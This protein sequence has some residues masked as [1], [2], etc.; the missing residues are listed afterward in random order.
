MSATKL[1]FMFPSELIPPEPSLYKLSTIPPP[2]DWVI[3]V[4]EHGNDL[5]CYGDDYWDYSAFGYRGF[6]FSI[7]KLSKANLKFVKQAMLLVLYHPNL[8]PG[9]LKSC[10]V[11][12]NCLTKIAK[13][14]DYQGIL[15]TDLPKFPRVQPLVAKSLQ[16]SQY[17]EYIS[18]LH[19]LRIF[20]DVVRFEIADK[21]TLA[22]LAS[23]QLDRE[24]VQ[25]PYIPPRIWSYQVNRLNEVL[26]DFL[27]HQKSIKM[28][29]TW[30][31]DARNHNQGVQI[32][33]I[34]NSPFSEPHLHQDKRIVYKKGFD[35]F[36]NRYGLRNL[37]EKWLEPKKSR[38]NL[39][40][41]YLNFVRDAALIYIANFS[42]QRIS[43][44]LSLRTD[45]FDIE[46]DERL[47]DVAL[48]SGKTT[49]T[50]PDDDARW[51][52]PITVKKAVDIAA[53]IAKLR[54]PY[55]PK[56]LTS[57]NLTDASMMLATPA[58]ESWS[59]YGN[60]GKGAALQGFDYSAFVRRKPC[61]FDQNT[62]TVTEDDW[63]IALSL[64]PNLGNRAG[65]GVGQ[66][67]IFTTHQLR[68]TI[69][70][71]MLTSNMVSDN[72]LQWL[73]KH[74]HRNM[75][76]YYG[77][78]YTNLRLNSEVE[79]ALII[80]SYRAVYQQL[81]AVVKNSV[82]YVRPHNKELIPS[83]VI[84]LVDARDEKQLL[85]L[86]K[87]GAVDCRPTLLGFCMKPG[88]CEYGGIE[89]VA[90]CAG[91]LSGG[92]CADAIFVRNSEAKLRNLIS[93]HE[94]EMESLD[95][96]EPRYNALKQEVYAIG[97]YLDV[98]DQQENR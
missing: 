96:S 47:G 57:S 56:K 6:N 42:M 80:E 15:M 3:S 17:K 7:Q 68:R 22:L 83:E 76:L 61:L 59:G 19:K 23:Y 18:F 50:D 97:V 36:L 33:S 95:S 21:K 43:E 81:V 77:R 46:R 9:T 13:T 86:I 65:F 20:S 4:D 75:T 93:T 73:M 48:I 66:P 82:E 39:I 37:I 1:N 92:I 11:R 5:S 45:C 98:I 88:P 34:Y 27:E 78:N 91:G 24:V 60:K 70:V 28:A 74:L 53:A 16:C 71:N 54:F 14:C 25:H 51:V 55:L 72:S 79:T 87:Q 12:F 58:W 26:D 32:S 8:F 30:I 49:K 29:F 44:V 64:T 38:I 67:W 31:S 85:K 41:T 10:Q 84:N 52:V 63:K 2:D 94:M 89:S 40:S 90:K 35:H 69:N 62:I